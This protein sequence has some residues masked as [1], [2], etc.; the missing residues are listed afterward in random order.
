MTA[1]ILDFGP[2]S[3]EHSLPPQNIEV[4]EAV[5]G[6]ILIDPN[7]MLRVVDLLE[8]EAFYVSHHATIYRAA[9]NLHNANQPTDL[10]T[11][12]NW[13]NDRNLLAQVGGRAKMA[14]LVDR[15]VT[16]VNV[17]VLAKIVAEKAL[18]RRMISVG[19]EINALSTLR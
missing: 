11:V 16:S 12:T 3:S 9:F 18:S 14:Q 2:N 1:Q 17:D 5:L 19:N 15:T 10:Q 8:P 13:L 4:E 7:A 6:G